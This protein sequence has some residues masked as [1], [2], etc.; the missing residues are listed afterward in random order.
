[1]LFFPY[2]YLVNI[3]V[4]IIVSGSIII[5]LVTF[6]F[7]FNL[8][9]WRENL[10]RVHSISNELFLFSARIA[11]PRDRVF[12]L[13][14][15]IENFDF[16]STLL[17]NLIIKT[18]NNIFF[19]IT[20]LMV[21]FLIKTLFTTLIQMTNLQIYDEYFYIVFGSLG[22]LSTKYIKRKNNNMN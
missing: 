11:N 21:V 22:A 13:Q 10:A 5:I 4:S 16:S 6:V 7:A 15:V 8:P 19:I 17:E 1:M 14:M 9:R 2:Y 18:E 20:W 3:T 12:I